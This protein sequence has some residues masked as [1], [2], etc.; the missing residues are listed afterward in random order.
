MDGVRVLFGDGWGLIRASNTQ[1]VLV[2]RYEARSQERLDEIQR[3]MEDWLRV[4]RRQ[5]LTTMSR[6]WLVPVIVTMA[7]VLVAGRIVSSWYVDYSWFAINGATRLWW[8]KA[9]NLSLL[10][11]VAFLVA[12]T[13]AFIN[14]FAVRSS[15][16]SLRMPRRI[17]NLEFSEEVSARILNRSVL[18]AVRR[19]RH[20]LR[21]DA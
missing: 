9:I 11:S 3:E 16:K 19:H 15:V 12:G 14:L 2:T 4:T 5:S 10:R 13:F 18:G 21:A 20:R 8:V 1:P 17:G 7:I 6:R